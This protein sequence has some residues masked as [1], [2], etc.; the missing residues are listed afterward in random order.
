MHQ[1]L[2]VQLEFDESADP[3]AGT[4]TAGRERRPFTGWLGLMAELQ[5]AIGGSQR[6][7]AQEAPALHTPPAA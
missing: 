1:P 7:S 4:L 6:R 3:I 2:R 5:D